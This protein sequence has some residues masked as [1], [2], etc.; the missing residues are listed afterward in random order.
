MNTHR[1]ALAV[2]C[3]VALTLA[4]SA[5]AKPGRGGAKGRPGRAVADLVN[6]GVDADAKG[7]LDIRHFP[8]VGKRTERSWLRLKAGNLDANGSYSLWMDD[9][10]TAEDLTLAQ[11]ADVSLDANDEGRANVRIDTKKGGVLPFGATLAGL[12]GMAFEIRDAGGAA[13][14]TGTVPALE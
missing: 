1:L 13:V 7:R 5:A 4:G 2:G 8:A 14:L 10:S 12:A 3:A 11:V 6:S 9:P